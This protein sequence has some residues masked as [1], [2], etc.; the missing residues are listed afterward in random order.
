MAYLA[1]VGSYSVNGVA[2]LHTELLKA[3]LFKE[4]YTLWPDK[5][6]NKT[7]GVTPRRWLANCNPTLNELISDKIGKEWIRDF[8][9]ISRL[10]RYYDD[11][12]FH[13][14][15]Q[16]AKRENKQR[17]VDLVKEQ[18]GVEFDVSMMFD[19]QV[20]RIHEYK[21]QLLNVLHVIHIY[22]RIRRGDT[23]DL[24]PRCCI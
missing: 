22:D 1:I 5:F 11:S 24:V 8:S 9:Q 23:Q 6:N 4:F 15:W 10:R 16:S 17:L 2:A 21:R 18:C 7:N 19:V 12:E 13:N 20:K 14:Q 3:G